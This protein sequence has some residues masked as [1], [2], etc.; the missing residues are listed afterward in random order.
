[1]VEIFEDWLAYARQWETRA[2]KI[3]PTVHAHV[4]GRPAGTGAFHR[5][6]EIATQAPDVWVGTRSQMVDHFL[7]SLDTGGTHAG[8]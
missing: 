4:F 8:H 6:L 2:I 3:D 5:I 7:Q 1:M